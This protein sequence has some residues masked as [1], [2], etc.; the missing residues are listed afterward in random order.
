MENT[1]TCFLDEEIIQYSSPLNFGVSSRIMKTPKNICQKITFSN[2]IMI[3]YI[4]TQR[5]IETEKDLTRLKTEPSRDEKKKD[6]QITKFI[7]KNEIQEIEENTSGE[8]ELI[9]VEYEEQKESLENNPFFLVQKHSYDKNKVQRESSELEMKKV[10]K[11]MNLKEQNKRKLIDEDKILYLRTTKDMLQETYLTKTQ[12]KPKLKRMSSLKIKRL[13]EKINTDKELIDN[14][15][16]RKSKIKNKIVSNNDNNE[17]KNSTPKEKPNIIY[18]YRNSEKYLNINIQSIKESAFKKRRESRTSSIEIK[19]SKD[20]NLYKSSLFNKNNS[21]KLKK[22]SDKNQNDKIEETKLKK[23]DGDKKTKKD[24]KESQINANIN[25]PKKISKRKFSVF[26]AN[27]TRIKKDKSLMK[28]TIIKEKIFSQKTPKKKM[29]EDDFEAA[30]KHEK[31][32]GKTQFNLFSPDKFT[33]TQFCGSDYL[34]YTLD[35]MQVI[36]KSNKFQKQQKSKVNFNFPNTKENKLK[37]KI[38]LFDLDETL[39][40]CTG[41]INLKKESYQHVIEIVLPGGKKTKVGIN[42]RPFWKKTLNLIKKHYHIVVFTA[43]HQAYADAVLDFMDPSNKYFKYR[44]YRNNCSL[45]DV[46]GAKFYV[47]DLDIFD[48]HYNLKDIIIIDNSAL[49]FI[50]HLENGIPIVPYYHEDE[51]GSLYVV[52]LYLMHIYKED[53][54]REANKKYINLNSFLNEAKN[55]KDNDTINSEESFV[56]N[57]DNENNN[58]NDS[59]NKS[60]NKKEEETI[61]EE[62]KPIKETPIENTSNVPS[63]TRSSFST[64]KFHNNLITKSRLIN[65]YYEINN[66]KFNSEKQNEEI[67]EEK[68]NKS[69]SIDDEEELKKN[70]NKNHKNIID[71]F[72]Q[73]RHLTNLDK[74]AKPRNQSKSNKTL[75][76]HLNANIIRTNFDDKFSEC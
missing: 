15:K 27:S 11:L 9:T 8:I 43:S 3:P 29:S 30:L 12:N 57:N 22:K 46:D 55:R 40:H 6:K 45:V 26:L 34:E 52:G 59:N 38:A 75:H 7:L 48:E 23:S 58:N 4:V 56:G 18:K 72:Y 68:N 24:K 19:D 42:I 44:L 54:L 1:K 53:D 63:P 69:F 70:K 62:V 61:K 36:L 47:K 60:V 64:E 5:N 49:S 16:P 37:K 73:K 21:L 31:N 74:S 28:D 71:Y 76:H 51:D 39:V 13:K 14:K 66:N 17:Y 50:Y 67:I 25:I 10:K 65:M 2:T 41:N 20:I 35:C 32:L 33:N